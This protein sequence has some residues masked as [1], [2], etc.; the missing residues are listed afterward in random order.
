[1]GKKNRQRIAKTIDGGINSQSS[2]VLNFCQAIVNG[3]GS[4][5]CR[6]VNV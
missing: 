2:L 4:E 5:V 3:G 6:Y 1:M